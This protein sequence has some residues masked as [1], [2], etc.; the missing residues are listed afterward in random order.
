M[1]DRPAR[2]ARLS[3]GDLSVL[4]AFAAALV[5]RVTDNAAREQFIDTRLGRVEES[6]SFAFADGDC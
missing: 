6:R 2:L 5:S 4:K 3:R 1:S